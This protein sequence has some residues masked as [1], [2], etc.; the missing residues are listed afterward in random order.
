MFVQNNLSVIRFL[1][2]VKININ[3][4][5]WA[6]GTLQI[7]LRNNHIAVPKPTAKNDRKKERTGP[8]IFAPEALK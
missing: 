5:I 1:C 7:I 4:L 2:L 8:S 3:Q 6:G